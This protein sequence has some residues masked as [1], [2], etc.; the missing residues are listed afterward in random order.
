VAVNTVN[1]RRAIALLAAPFAALAGRTVPSAFAAPRSG[2]GELEAADITASG[3]CPESEE[4]AFLG[5]INDYR[6]AN[7]LSTLKLS[8]TLGAAAEHHSQDMAR[9]NYFSHT[10]A[11]GQSWSSNITSHGYTVSSTMGENIAAGNRTASGTFT[12]WKNSAPHNA[13]MLSAKFKAIGI[14]RASSSTSKYGYYWT[15]TFGGAFDASPTC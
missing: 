13:N 12:Q 14:G 11:N 5:L 4:L 15:T 3:Y 7:G 8:R 9:N 2:A 10:L 1:R 6:R